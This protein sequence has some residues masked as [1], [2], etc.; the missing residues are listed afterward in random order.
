MIREN[1]ITTPLPNPLT[2]NFIHHCANCGAPHFVPGGAQEEIDHRVPQNI[3]SGAPEQHEAVQEVADPLAIDRADPII[4]QT[5]EVVWIEDAE[6]VNV[7]DD[8]APQ[9]EDEDQD[10]I[11]I[12]EVINISEEEEDLWD[13]DHPTYQQCLEEAVLWG[14]QIFTDLFYPNGIHILHRQML[15]NWAK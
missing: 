5:T 9:Y 10:V 7:P 15:K 3:P 1:N 4:D 8:P 14:E 2:S 6:V 12:E 13:E 11:F